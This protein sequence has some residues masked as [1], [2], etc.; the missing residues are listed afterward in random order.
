MAKLKVTMQDRTVHD[1]PI[2]PTLE[3]A[4][5]NYAKK[6]FHKAFIADQKQSDVYWLAYEGLRRAGHSPKAF[7]EGFLDTLKSVDVLDDD[8]LE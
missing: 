4:F 7:G 6:P 8:P 1:L 2:T 3:C 5:D